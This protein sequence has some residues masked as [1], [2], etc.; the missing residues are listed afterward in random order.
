[1]E[2]VAA[3]VVAATPTKVPVEAVEVEVEE[4]KSLKLQST[5]FY[6]TKQKVSLSVVGVQEQHSVA[7]AVQV[8][9]DFMDEM[10]D[11]LALIQPLL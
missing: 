7:L 2:Q 6:Q 8:G 4:D 9:A 11:P 1:L 3:E 10:A 5:I